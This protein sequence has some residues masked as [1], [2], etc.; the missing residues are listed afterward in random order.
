MDSV[1][2]ER[3]EEED[4]LFINACS[5]SGHKASALLPPIV[6]SLDPL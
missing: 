4:T 6:F 5:V 1:S 2:A 3:R